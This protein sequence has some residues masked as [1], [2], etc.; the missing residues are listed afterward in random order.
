[1]IALALGGAA[2]L[3]HKTIAKGRD[4]DLYLCFDPFGNFT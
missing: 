3:S 2:P 1:M 4:A